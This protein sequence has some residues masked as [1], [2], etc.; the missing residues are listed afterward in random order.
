MGTDHLFRRTA[1][2]RLHHFRQYPTTLL[3]APAGFGKSHLLSLFVK[4]TP[5]PV[6]WM[7]LTKKDR[8]FHSFLDHLQEEL[9][10]AF[11]GEEWDFIGKKASS[12]L[13]QE[14]G[15][16]EWIHQWLDRLAKQKKDTIILVDQF[17][18]IDEASAVS[19][20]IFRLI[21]LLPPEVHLLFATRFMP[22]NEV[23]KKLFLQNKV[24]EVSEH[25]L[26]L[27][28]EEISTLFHRFYRMN[29]TE[30]EVDEIA[31]LSQGWQILVHFIYLYL[32]RGGELEQI[33]AEPNRSLRPFF[34]FMEEEIF[35]P[36][37]STLQ[38]FLKDL[39]LIDEID[40]EVLHFL[41]FGMEETLLQQLERYRLFFP[42]TN[43]NGRRI[44]PLFRL[45]LQ[46]K[47]PLETKKNI[48]RRLAHYYTN[49]KEYP[50]SFPH[51][52]AAGE[53]EDLSY[54]LTKIGPQ[55]MQLGHLKKV[56]ETIQRIP[57]PYRRS[58]GR[59]FIVEGDYYRLHSDYDRALE[60]YKEARRNCRDHGD[61]DGELMAI[62]GEILVYLDT[63]QPQQ[64]D[65]LLHHDLR[66]ARR[67][68]PTLNRRILHLIA[69][70]LINIGKPNR[71]EKIFRLLRRL[72]QKVDP[73]IY[74]RLL[75]RTGRLQEANFLLSKEEKVNREE[76]PL[77]YGF[78]ESSLVHS[79]VC[80]FLGEGEKAKKKAQQGILF[81]AEMNAPFVEAVGWSRM[82]HA[83]STFA[84]DQAHLAEE[85]YLTS[86]EIFEEIGV[87]RGPAEPMM[88]LTF[89]YGK[90]GKYDLALSYGEKAYKLA[91]S[92][93][94]LWIG[95]LT[96]LG[97][98]IASFYSKK[99]KEAEILFLETYQQAIECKDHFLET[100][101]SLWLSLLY[102][103]LERMEDFKEWWGRTLT[104]AIEGQYDFLFT[105]S[106]FLSPKDPQM[107]IPLFIRSQ[108]DMEENLTHYS[109]KIL[110]KMGF[111]DLIFHPGYTLRV[112]TLGRFRV[113]LGDRE[114]QEKDWQRSS[115][116]RLFQY[117]LSK[118]NRELP[119]EMIQEDLWPE[120]DEDTRERDFKVSLNAL[121]RA[122]EP[123]RKA[124]SSS[125]YIFRQG[126]N[127]RL[128]LHTG[129]FL[130]VEDF[131]KEYEKG[132]VLKN[133]E[134]AITLLMRGFKRYHG[135]FLPDNL[136]DDWVN[137]ER[138]RLSL[139]FLKG[140]ERLSL[141]LLRAKRENE[142][143]PVAEKMLSIDPL[144]E[145]AY[146]ILM[147]AYQ[148]LANR[149]LSL[150]WY[151][152]CKQV[153]ERE[154]GV[155]PMEETT[156]LYRQILEGKDPEIMP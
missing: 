19:R 105:H 63:V 102:E 75:L 5:S 126:S 60:L 70:N 103:R 132:L 117:F 7:T 81:A 20:F 28:K 72:N 121:T 56:K 14:E 133:E 47:T 135:D 112:E 156:Y 26:L 12:M 89:L 9:Y 27:N 99:E 57:L 17:H 92:V 106:S 93:S 50:L 30:E 142:A 139:L 111:R 51:Y 110:E 115:A 67:M 127:Y 46:D 2:D 104:L 44:H 22:E 1:L 76:T 71:A 128:Q 123:E 118:R 97:M 134:D 77:Y 42:D 62:E 18:L 150:W 120:A 98:G 143:I 41:Y 45:L 23:M 96:K 36:L 39:A 83:V 64:A 10:H 87:A 21:E 91:Q 155:P 49:R 114:L 94:D 11:P 147:V 100:A 141:L 29:R 16:D 116:K 38:G 68:E 129:F 122:L 55:L 148:R 80:A 4:E 144:W 140:S 152:K 85:S 66:K 108:E 146:R 119:K 65:S 84:S 138:E 149:T 137:E 34:E 124:R 107:M 33:H 6:L 52:I 40:R 78:R 74:S 58:F 13:Y 113:Y 136:Y 131:E 130:D 54:L 8:S 15:G 79:I 37:S 82:G 48:H 109:K 32:S 69:E 25:H 53:W 125:Y 59:L 95:A 90:M 61:Y 88:G 43:G 154:L 151:E 31:H 145:S 3:L 24:L 86:L 153:L 101:S 35:I 73:M